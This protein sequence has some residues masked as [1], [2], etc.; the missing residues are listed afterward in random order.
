MCTRPPSSVGRVDFP[1][2]GPTRRAPPGE[3]PADQNPFRPFGV[4]RPVEAS[5]ASVITELPSPH[6]EEAQSALLT[7]GLQASGVVALKAREESSRLPR[8]R[9]GRRH[10]PLSRT[11]TGLDRT[12]QARPHGRSARTREKGRLPFHPT[13]SHGTARNPGRALRGRRGRCCVALPR[14]TSARV[15]DR[16]SPPEDV[17]KPR[18]CRTRGSAAAVSDVAPT[19]FSP[20][21]HSPR[22]LLPGADGGSHRPAKSPSSSGGSSA[23]GRRWHS[24]PGSGRCSSFFS[25]C[26]GRRLRTCSSS[27]RSSAS[28]WWWIV[29]AIGF[30]GDV[31][32]LFWARRS[33]PLRDVARLLRA[34][35]RR[36]SVIRCLPARPWLRS[37]S[38]KK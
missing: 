35:P 3:R 16:P 34:A 14:V 15:S 31:L 10:G 2:S 4:P 27:R 20:L 1:A 19:G 33:G 32:T 36:R 6:D 38:A 5:L 28:T 26:P 8:R 24:T 7:H 12:S 11:R 25:S 22:A 23:T 30:A 13:P 21:C 9:P 18:C 29:V 37:T 17:G